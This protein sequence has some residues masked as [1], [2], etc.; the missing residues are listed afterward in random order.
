MALRSLPA[1]AGAPAGPLLRPGDIVLVK[2]GETIAA[3]GTVVEGRGA[4]AEAIN[5]RGPR[6]APSREPDGPRAT[7]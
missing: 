3:D 5:H 1:E 4:V 7:R 2:A 6:S